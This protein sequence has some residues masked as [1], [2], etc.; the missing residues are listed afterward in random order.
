[1]IEERGWLFLKEK[2]KELAAPWPDDGYW[3]GNFSVFENCFHARCDVITCRAAAYDAGT[4]HLP[5]IKVA[6][7]FVNGT[8]LL[9]TKDTSSHR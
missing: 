1:M 8:L 5:I 3:A 4:S 9:D 7:M 6:F 2:E